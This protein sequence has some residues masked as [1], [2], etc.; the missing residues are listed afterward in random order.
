MMIQLKHC[1]DVTMLENNY[2]HQKGELKENIIYRYNMPEYSCECCNFKTIDKTKFKRHMDSSKHKEMSATPKID[3]L[4]ELKAMVFELTNTINT[5]KQP[6]KQPIKIEPIEQPI[7]N[8]EKKYMTVDEEKKYMDSVCKKL[9]DDAM[10]WISDYTPK[11][12]VSEDC[13]S[14]YIKVE[15]YKYNLLAKMMI[16]EYPDSYFDD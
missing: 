13:K 14:P 10:E 3:E 2:I 1:E 16:A 6:I 12:K 5:L 9:G 4:A 15:N 8:E 11:Q 7:K